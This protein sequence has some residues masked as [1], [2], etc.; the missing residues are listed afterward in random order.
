MRTRIS[1]GRRRG[2]ADVAERGRGTTGAGRRSLVTELS[3]YAFSMVREDELT[4]YRGSG[5]GL[6]PI[7]LVMPVAEHPSL[8]TLKRLE[9]EYALRTELDSGWAARPLA[10]TRHL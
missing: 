4:L 1:W 8:E 10:L 6:A 9:H 7:L 5:D 2:G 3:S